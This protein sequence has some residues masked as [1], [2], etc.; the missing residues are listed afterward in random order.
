MRVRPWDGQRARRMAQWLGPA[1]EAV[2]MAAEARATAVVARGTTAAVAVT[3][4]PPALLEEATAALQE[5]ATAS[6]SG[7]SQMQAR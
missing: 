7:V 2:E 6:G 5:E 1:F 4:M 3:A